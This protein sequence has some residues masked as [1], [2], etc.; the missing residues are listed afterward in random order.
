MTPLDRA[1][2]TERHYFEM[3]ARIEQLDGAILAWVPGLAACPAGAVIHRANAEM[4]AHRGAPW[5]A[6]AERA[7][8]NAGVALA[9]IYLDSRGPADELLRRAGYIDREELV[10]AHSLEDGGSELTLRPVLTPDDWQRKLEL[11]QAGDISP[12]GHHVPAAEWVALER[13]KC[14]DGMEAYLAEAGGEIVGAI[15]AIRGDGILR[16][17]NILIH[18]A[19]RRQGLARAMLHRL[20]AIGREQGISEQCVFAVRGDAGEQLYRSSGMQLVGAQVEWSK[21]LGVSMQ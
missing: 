16:M 5:I 8:S 7:L 10:F 15:G 9:R 6:E 3:G 19:H 1:I 17:K 21:P 11:H 12:D 4:I 2:E 20:A 18:P 13:R 14:D